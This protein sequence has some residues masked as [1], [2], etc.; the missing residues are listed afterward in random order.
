MTKKL[1]ESGISIYDERKASIEELSKLSISFYSQIS[2]KDDCSVTYDSHLDKNDFK[3]LLKQSFNRDVILG[4]TTTGIHRDDVVF[5]FNNALL[6]NTGS[7][8]QKKSFLLSLKFAQYQSIYEKK[9]TPPI[10]LLDD[11]FDKLDTERTKK[12]YEIIDGQNF[13]QI[14]ITDTDKTLLE[15]FVYNNKHD[16]SFW[17]LEDGKISM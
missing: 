5:G 1:V 7:Q 16:G 3:T 11:L 6:K 2:D 14:F 4:Y 12:V 9:K 10:L 15:S 13:G 8:G 17:R